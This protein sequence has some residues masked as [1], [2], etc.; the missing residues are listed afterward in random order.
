MFVP[1]SRHLGNV[2]FKLHES[3]EGGAAVG[4]VTRG[5]YS[6]PCL[7]AMRSSDHRWQHIPAAT[8][9]WDKRI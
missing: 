7:G 2:V 6:C 4:A 5:F 8:Q 3:R 1:G 9:D